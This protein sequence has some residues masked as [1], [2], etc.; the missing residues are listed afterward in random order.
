MGVKRPREANPR[1]EVATF[2]RTATR[3]AF[4]E[5]IETDARHADDY[6][7][8]DLALVIAES[9]GRRIGSIR[10]LD[11]ADL[12]LA[13]GVITWRAESDKKRRKW[14]VPM[15]ERLPGELRAYMMKAG[16]RSGPLFPSTGDPTIPMSRYSFDGYL[17]KAEKHANLP[18][19]PGALWHAYR[20]GW[21]TSRKHMSPVDVAA[22]GRWADTNTLLRYYQQPD[23][24][25]MLAVVNE[26]RKL[27]EKVKTRP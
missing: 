8:V 19:L 9:T 14:V 21:A 3:A 25:T 23:Y 6:R 20:R 16:I 15:P 24:E 22:V 27:T 18:K 17:L 7:R 11:C 12:D 1:R 13:K 5:L 2:E 26:P 10:N 4:T